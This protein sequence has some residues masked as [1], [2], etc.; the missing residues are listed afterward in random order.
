MVTNE[1]HVS[2]RFDPACSSNPDIAEK[3]DTIIM[4]MTSRADSSIA[5]DGNVSAIGNSRAFDAVEIDRVWRVGV[6]QDHVRI[7]IG[8]RFGGLTRRRVDPVRRIAAIQ[9]AA[10]ASDIFGRAIY[11][12]S[13]DEPFPTFA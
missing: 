12:R 9:S 4:R 8:N 10:S 6:R 13:A 11:S 2:V 5:A 7:H 3:P 1:M